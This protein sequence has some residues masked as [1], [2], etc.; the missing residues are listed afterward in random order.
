MFRVSRI[1]SA[2]SDDR[3]FSV[4]LVGAALRQGIF[5][6]KMHELGWTDVKFFETQDGQLT[7]H[8]CVARYHA[9]VRFISAFSPFLPSKNL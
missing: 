6:E 9:Q 7:L 1:L 4:D 2:Y 3:P 8:H 5:V